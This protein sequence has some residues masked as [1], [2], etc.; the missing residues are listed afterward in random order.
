MGYR[1]AIFGAMVAVLPPGAQAGDQPVVVELYTSQGCSSCPPADEL[2]GKLAGHADVL[3]LALHVDYWDYI[4]WKDIFADPAH[5]RRQKN[6]ARAAGQRTIYTPQMV[7]GG[8]DHVVGYEPMQVMDLIQKHKRRPDLVPLSVKR[9]GPTLQIS[10]D[11]A[12]GIDGALTVNLVQYTPRETVAIQR[13]E[14]A[15]RSLTYSNIVTDWQVLGQWDGT[16]PLEIETQADGPGA[17]L[18][19]RPDF[20]AIVAA[21]RID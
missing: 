20:G 6:Y 2:V 5:T 21:A 3:A 13:G 12:P 10:A 17:V 16:A 19:Q 8:V 15:G 11:A 18:L 14:N 1:A 4:G 9:Q 7:I